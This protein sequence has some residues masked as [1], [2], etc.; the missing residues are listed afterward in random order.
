MRVDR[1]RTKTAARLVA[2]TAADTVRAAARAFADANIGLLVVC[3]DDGAAIGVL[4]KSDL[5]RHLAGARPA[6]ASLRETMSCDIVACDPEDDV[7]VAWQM[8]VTRRL[9]NMPVL[10]AAARPIGVLDIRD[11]LAALL[12]QE[13]YHERLLEDY[14]AGVGYR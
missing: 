5:V 7:Y 11:A 6:E 8:M 13:K 12:D 10:D 14:A 4:S 3:G 2:I 9:Q 1:L